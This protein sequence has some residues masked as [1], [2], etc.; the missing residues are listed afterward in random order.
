MRLH[1]RI[2]GS[3]CVILLNFAVENLLASKAGEKVLGKGLDMPNFRFKHCCLIA[4]PLQTRAF[5]LLG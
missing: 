3:G 5:L 2:S 4:L 1:A